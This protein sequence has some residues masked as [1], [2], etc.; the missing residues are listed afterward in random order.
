MHEVEA[1]ETLSHGRRA[2]L[3]EDF[4]HVT[5]HSPS[6][7]SMY[8]LAALLTMLSPLSPASNRHT[9]RTTFRLLSRD[10]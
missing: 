2:A 7:P 6:T 5:H 9:M 4:R 10:S 8:P 3:K 1:A